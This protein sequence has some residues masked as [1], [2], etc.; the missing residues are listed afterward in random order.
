MS[1]QAD[2]RGLQTGGKEGTVILTIGWNL[3]VVTCVTWWEWGAGEG[4]AGLQN[5]KE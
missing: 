1:F 2:N 3:A 5:R 4:W